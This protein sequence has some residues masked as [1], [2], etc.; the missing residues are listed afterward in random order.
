M[1]KKG[2]GFT[3]RFPHFG[4]F[5][6]IAVVLAIPLTVWS[7]NNVSTNTSQEAAGKVASGTISIKSLDARFQGA[8]NFN[9]TVSGLK[10]NQYPMIVVSCYQNE[11]LVY[12]QLDHSDATF[13][14]GGGS[15]KW[16]QSPGPASCKAIL[17]A[18]GGISKG[19]D[20]IVQLAP[21]VT[22]EASQ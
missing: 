6:V 15:S 7:L 5:I 18:Y 3:E 12:A 17:Y 19:N 10:G 13:I 21:P 20:T 1:A 9:T 11:E 2:Y 22:F 8:V 16:W 14:L 4:I